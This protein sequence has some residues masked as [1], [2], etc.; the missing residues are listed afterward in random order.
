MDE[1]RNGNTAEVLA[2]R[3]LSFAYQS[4]S[5]VLH[6]IHLSVGERELVAVMG[7]SG[8]GKST[9]LRCIAGLAEPDTGAI[10]VRGRRI[11]GRE[12][13]RD[14]AIGMVF[15]QFNLFPHRTVRDN[16]V[17]PLRV[18]DR[19]PLDAAVRIAVEHLEMVGL[20]GLGDRRPTTLSGGQQQRLAIARMLAMRPRILLLDEITSALDATLTADVLAIIR[21]LADTGLPMLMVTH[22]LTFAKRFADRIVVLHD[23]RIV[24]ETSPEYERTLTPV[25]EADQ[26]PSTPR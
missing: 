8:S 7:R 3:G 16:I 12:R 19:V 5:P 1:P 15:Q 26:P 25:T 23:G 21:R 20:S 2:V 6:D 13:R 22:E 17:M 18:V 24:T 10:L 4:G 9:L 14:N 11:S